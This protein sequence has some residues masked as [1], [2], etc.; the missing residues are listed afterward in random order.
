MQ[1]TYKSITKSDIEVMV[2]MMQKFYAID[3]YPMNSELSKKLLAEF[4][5]D[6]KLGK[7]WLISTENGIAGYVIL[8]FV[9]S[10]EYGGTIAFLDELFLMEEARGKGIGKQAIDF[11]Q[12]EAKKSGL[13]LI[14][15]EVEPRNEKAKRLYISSD[16]EMHNRKFMK[17]KINDK[18]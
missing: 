9:F 4:I 14:Y 13:K 7:A 11:I 3:N 15:L 6:E 16:F 1:A 10:F 5:A 2:S 12:Q 17:Y 8:T 18:S